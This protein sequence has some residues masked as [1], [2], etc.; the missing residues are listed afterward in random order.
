MCFIPKGK[1]SEQGICY[2]CKR[3]NKKEG[4]VVPTSMRKNY[5]Q[6]L[7]LTTLTNTRDPTCPRM[8]FMGHL[9]LLRTICHVKTLGNRRKIVVLPTSTL[10]LN[11]NTLHHIQLSTQSSF[12]VN[13]KVI[14]SYKGHYYMCLYLVGIEINAKPQSWWPSWIYAN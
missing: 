11:Q 3:V 13:L 8:N 4:L 1:R 10:C 2:W 6:L 14:F 9:L 12:I 5:L 7:A